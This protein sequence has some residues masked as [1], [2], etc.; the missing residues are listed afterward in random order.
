M[1]LVAAVAGESDCHGAGGG[2]DGVGDACLGLGDGWPGL[3][4]GCR[5]LGDGCPGVGLG[6]ACLGLGDGWLGLGDGCLG[7]GEERRGG[8]SGVA[9]L[10]CW[11]ASGELRAGFIVGVELRGGMSSRTVRGR[12]EIR[13]TRL[14]PG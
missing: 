10:R 7:L 4:D 11:K 1:A 3:D 8:S 9:G 13:V 2:G 12:L 6:D 14:S 5:G